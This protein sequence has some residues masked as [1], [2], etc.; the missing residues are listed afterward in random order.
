MLYA[1]AHALCAYCF[2]GIMGLNKP[3]TL[4]NVFLL[5]MSRGFNVVEFHRIWAWSPSYSDLKP[6]YLSEYV[7]SSRMDQQIFKESTLFWTILESFVLNLRANLISFVNMGK[8]G[9]PTATYTPT[10]AEGSESQ[11]I[12]ATEITWKSQSR[13]FDGNSEG[14]S[15]IDSRKPV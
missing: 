4:L 11:A 8:K 10:K 2:R 15:T 14:S 7:P 9:K 5:I 6:D 1:F 3:C 13:A 12:S